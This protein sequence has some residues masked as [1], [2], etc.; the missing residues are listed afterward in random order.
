[1]GYTPILLLILAAPG[2]AGKY[3]WSITDLFERKSTNI[4]LPIPWPWLVPL[5]R[6]A[7]IYTFRDFTIGV[8]FAAVL[9]LGV[10]GLI[11]IGYGRVKRKA[12]EPSLVAAICLAL[13]Y[14]HYAFSRADVGHLALSIFP[15]MVTSF[16]LLSDQARF[17]KWTL[18]FV[19]GGSSKLVM[20]PIHPGWSARHNVTWGEVVVV[21][22]CLRV[23]PD[24]SEDLSLFI[25]LCDEFAP[26][27]RPFLVTPYPPGAYAAMNRRSPAWEI[28]SVSERSEAFK[29]EEIRRIEEAAPGF[30]LIL[31]LPLDGREA[32]RFRNT[33]WA[34]DHFI[35]S[36]YKQLKD[37]DAHSKFEIFIPN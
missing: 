12:M 30:I 2:F 7:T 8:Y 4:S 9:G 13:P 25:R 3:W 32:L 17:T 29:N 21:G 16:L 11:W 5:A 14:A 6:D 18:G 34:L 10:L 33:H 26:V 20:L 37:Y 23:S 24:V 36:R 1:M 27:D 28:Y 15:V 22:S 31:D 19:L 35:R